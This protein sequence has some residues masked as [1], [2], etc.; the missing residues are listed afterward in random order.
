MALHVQTGRLL[1]YLGA[2]QRKSHIFWV[3]TRVLE[4][5]GEDELEVEQLLV[6][7][8]RGDGWGRVGHDAAGRVYAAA[9]A[10][11]ATVGGL[12][13]DRA[14]RLLDKTRGHT[15]LSTAQERFHVL[16]HLQTQ[17]QKQ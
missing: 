8:S 13:A 10:T 14:D 5:V 2:L 15:R 12:W 4:H 16:P 1:L 17:Q 9:A 6:L 3:E 11:I 7:P